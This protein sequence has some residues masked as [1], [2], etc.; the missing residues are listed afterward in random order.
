MKKTLLGACLSFMMLPLSAQR[1]T[2][3]VDV[4][5][6][7][8]K[9]SPTLFGLFLED[10]NLSADGGL[11][12]ELLRNRSFEDADT[13]CFWTFNAQN[14]S[15]EIVNTSKRGERAVPLNFNNRQFLRVNA[16]GTFTIENNGYWGISVKKGESYDFKA[17]LRTDASSAFDKSLT[18]RLVDSHNNTLASGNIGNLK[19][20][21]TYSSVSLTPN[22]SC[23]DAHLEICGE[24][25]GNVCLDMVSLMPQNGWGKS[26]VRSDLG[27][28][29]NALR[30]TFFRFPGGCWVEGDQLSD[31][32]QWKQ[33][34]GPID[35]RI[36]LWNIWGYKATHGI[37]YHEYL[38]L[39][40]DLGAEPL[41]C[42]NAGV[43][44]RD[45]VNY[46]LL[47]QWVQ[48]ALDAI[49]YANGPVTSVWG[50]ARARNGHPEP[51]GLKYLEIGNENSG[52]IYFDNYKRIALA[53]KARYPEMQLV[54]NDWAGAHPAD[55][56][57]E[58]I[59]EHYYDKPEWFVLNAARYD[60]M[61]RGASKVFIGEYAVTS[62]TGNGNLRGAIG[63]AAFMTGLERNSDYVA[64]AAYAPLLCNVKH[65]RWPINLIN[66]DNHRW[67]GLPSYYVQQMFAAN[68]GTD[69]LPITVNGGPTVQVPSAAGGIGL[70]T[71]KNT[72]EFKDLKVTTP[73][74]KVLYNGDFAANFDSWEKKGDGKWSVK[75]GVLCQSSYGTGVTAYFG[76]NNGSL[77]KPCVYPKMSDSL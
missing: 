42:I 31:R 75:D 15:A 74:G 23:D 8:H 48:D 38:Q 50:A 24:G 19:N 55:P 68:Q 54:S 39:A 41:F 51:F 40:E 73:Q 61:P 28:A 13:L 12:R 77:V 11:Y 66:F 26:G 37:G 45:A 58:L 2:I 57:P 34:I 20:N 33:T 63:E 32:Y 65:K 64:M 47:D 60:S 14:G 10:I 72:A 18:V 43:A 53:V 44:H 30:P 70:G 22:N 7:D 71:W 5:H 46:E 36:P 35:S 9:I 6:P 56:V 52:S 21:W 17:A 67:Y 76:E 1:A 25:K 4:N 62:G 27:E 69:N 59:D 16:E 29:L 49:E 3:S